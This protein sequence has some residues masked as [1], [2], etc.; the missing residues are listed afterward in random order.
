MKEICKNCEFWHTNQQM[1]NYNKSMGFCNL[2]TDIDSAEFLKERKFVI[3]IHNAFEKVQHEY[4]NDDG[5]MKHFYVEL[6]TYKKFGCIFFEKR[7]K[8]NNN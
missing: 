8:E 6:C 2:D 4:L 5:T 7:N 1:L 3:F